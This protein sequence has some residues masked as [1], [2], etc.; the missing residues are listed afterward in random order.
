MKVLYEPQSSDT[1]EPILFL[2]TPG[3]LC[4]G[5]LTSKTALPA[6]GIYSIL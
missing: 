6:R 1:G 2:R 3:T 4:P 5:G